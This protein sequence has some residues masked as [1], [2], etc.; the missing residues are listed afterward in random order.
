M[1]I[2]IDV[3]QR[4][5]EI[6][7]FSIAEIFQDLNQHGLWE[8]I[9]RKQLRSQIKLVFDTD[10][11]GQWPQRV[12][13]LPHPLLRDT[14]RMFRSLQNKTAPGN[15]DRRSAQS[16]AW[17]TSVEYAQYHEQPDR[18]FARPPARPWFSLLVESSQ[19]NRTLPRVVDEWAQ[20][21]IRAVERS[22]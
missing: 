9:L 22:R 13:N 4:E 3:D 6:E 2:N 16:W 7:I 17:G 1:P 14:R 10:G 21:A 18:P 12:D 20:S 11:F 8:Y 5:V 15:I 19:F